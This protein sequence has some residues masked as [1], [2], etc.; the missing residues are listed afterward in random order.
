MEGSYQ[1]LGF[2]ERCAPVE[3]K[4]VKKRILI[5]T[6]AGVVLVALVVWAFYYARD[7]HFVSEQTGYKGDIF[8][9]TFFGHLAF[10]AKTFYRV[11]EYPIWIK[12][13]ILLFCFCIPSSAFVKLEYQTHRHKA[14]QD[15]YKV[16]T[17]VANMTAT[18]NNQRMDDAGMFIMSLIVSA[19]SGPFFAVYRVYKL[20]VL[21]KYLGK[22]A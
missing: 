19:L 11:M 5:S 1:K 20:R 4:K 10:N 17:Y 3:Q 15:L 12:S 18:S 9:P 7:T 8:I 22:T 14:E 6:I 16:G 2:C 13:L 21:Q